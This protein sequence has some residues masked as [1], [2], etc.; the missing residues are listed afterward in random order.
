MKTTVKVKWLDDCPSC[1][2]DDAAVTGERITPSLLQSGN[3]V[4][5][6]KC[7]HKGEIDADG[8]NAW[9]EWDEVKR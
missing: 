3:S 2:F 9:V 5:C 6:L 1:G 8:E 7:G 4:E